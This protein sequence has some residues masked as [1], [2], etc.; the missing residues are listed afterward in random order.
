MNHWLTE[1][2]V[3]CQ[4]LISGADD[5]GFSEAC[6]ERTRHLKAQMNGDFDEKSI[7]RK[8]EALAKQLEKEFGGDDDERSSKVARKLEQAIGS[9]EWRKRKFEDMIR[10]MDLRVQV[11]RMCRRSLRKV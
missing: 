2:C 6:L 5:R 3:G 4:A 8:S 1:G 9:S 10:K 7:K 11:G